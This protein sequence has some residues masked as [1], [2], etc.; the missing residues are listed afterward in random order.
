MD[1]GFTS[2][3]NVPALYSI[4]ERYILR[5]G[6]CSCPAAVSDISGVEPSICIALEDGIIFNWTIY[7]M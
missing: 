5:I 6:L 2:G 1:G 3:L 4:L 7:F